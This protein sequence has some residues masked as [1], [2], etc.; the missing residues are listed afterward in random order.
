M[1]YIYRNL[2]TI[3]F[4]LFYKTYLFELPNYFKVFSKGVNF[5]MHYQKPEVER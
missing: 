3:D 1:Y 4:L 5:S 2:K